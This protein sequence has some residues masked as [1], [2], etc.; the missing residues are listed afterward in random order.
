MVSDQGALFDAC[1]DCGGVDG[2]HGTIEISSPDG[3]I[4]RPCPRRLSNPA[5]KR[6]GGFR[7]DDRATSR[8][9][10]ISQYPRSGSNKLRV[11]EEFVAAGSRGL[12]HGELTERLSP[13]NVATSTWRSRADELEDGGWLVDSGFVRPSPSGRP[14]TVWI[15]SDAAKQEIQ[16]R[17]VSAGHG[18]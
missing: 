18:G 2:N 14:S 16:R 12:T 6:I 7:K 15:L 9:A 4:E 10:A 1:P 11:L 3:P 17:S 8:A 5:T 13:G